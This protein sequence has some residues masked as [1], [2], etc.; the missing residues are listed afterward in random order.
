MSKIDA[1]S[2]IQLPPGYSKVSKT[3]KNLLFLLCPKTQIVVKRTAKFH[4]LESES[5][6]RVKSALSQMSPRH[7][8]L[9]LK[10]KTTDIKTILAYRDVIRY[11]TP[12]PPPALNTG[13][14]VQHTHLLDAGWR[15][16]IVLGQE[17][18]ER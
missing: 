1:V 10:L 4:V 2:V 7:V 17:T 12:T 11:Y 8:H 16:L 9:I 5:L 13:A 15:Q 18:D 14:C 6:E 3:I